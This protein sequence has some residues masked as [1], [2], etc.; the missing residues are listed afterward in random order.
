MT[1]QQRIAAL[2]RQLAELEAVPEGPFFIRHRTVR[3]T[4][5]VEIVT[6]PDGEAARTAET[7]ERRGYYTE[8]GR[9]INPNVRVFGP[10]DTK[11]QAEN[12]ERA[13]TEDV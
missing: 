10:F 9:G 8:D 6:A 2:K 13:W 11:Q 4:V 5:D 3:H 12:S 7:L 1:K